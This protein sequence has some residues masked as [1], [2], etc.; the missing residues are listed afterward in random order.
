MTGRTL[1]HYKILDKLGQGGMGVLYRALD[2]HLDRTVAIKVL[3]PEAIG[4]PER[5]RRFVL[6]AKA[7]SA[8]NH[9][10]II[11]IYD[12]D[13]AGGVDFIA[14]EYVDGQSLDRLI[15][16]GP[17]PKEQALGYGVQIAAALAAAHA[18]GIVHRDIKPANVMV[19]TTGLVKVLDFG[20]AKLTER[21]V[22]DEAAPTVTA[23]RETV[24]GVVLGTVAYMSPE[25]AEGK[26][27]D[28]RSDVFSFGAM[29]YEMLAGRR[30]FAGDSN[31]SILTAILHRPPEPIDVSHDLR[32]IL[33][34][35]L[36]KRREA[37]Y[38]SAAEMGK[39]LEA[40][41]SR[42]M[43]RRGPLAVAAALSIAALV[44]VAIWLGVRA[45]RV[46]WARNVALPEIAGL[47][48]KDRLLAAEHLARQ[49]ERYLPADPL[50]QR[51]RGELLAP[52]SIRTEPPGADV[53]VRDY[54]DTDDPPRW[55]HLGRSPLE[56]VPL[57]RARLG[58]R[59]TREGFPALEGA[60]TPVGGFPVFQ[61]PLHSQSATPEGM[62]WIPAG[63]YVHPAVTPLTIEGFWL[64]RYEVTN[65]QYKQFVDRGGYRNR[66]YWKQPFIKDGRALPWEQAMAEF[67][68]STGRPGPATWELGTFPEGRA[69]FPV[70]GVSWH[71]AAA[72]AEFAGKSLPTVYHWYRAAEIFISSD[73]LRLSNLSGRGPAP[74]G[75]F[76]GLGPFGAYDM[77]GNI[78]E[79]CWNP[80][81]ERRYILGG[82]WTE[83]TYLYNIP[84]ARAP[85]ERSPTHGFRCARQSGAPSQA[86]AGAV[87]FVVRDRTRDKPAGDD[88]FR[89]YK[90]VHSYDR[91]ELKAAIESLDDTSEYWR[92]EKVSFQ[93]AYGNERVPAYLLLPKNA[94]PPYQTVVYFP[95]AGVLN[96]RSS[97]RLDLVWFDFIVRSGRAVMYPVYKGTYERGPSRYY[98]R[99]GQ[100]NLWREMNLQ[101]SK[102]LGRSI[103]YLETR[104]DI[105]RQRLAY[106]GVSLGAAQGPRLMAVEDRFRTGVLLEGGFFE[107]VAPEVDP[108]HFAPRVKIPTLMIN[109]RDDFLFPLE[110]SQRPLFRLLGT[111][112]KDK[113][114]VLFNAGHDIF[115]P[116][117]IKVVLDWLDRYLGPVKPL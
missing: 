111:P 50:I 114:H 13:Q 25:Q 108:L 19:T 11:T 104:P 66:D 85:F 54:L 103:D 83:G 43:F 22:V 20:L 97:E 7:A 113:R 38:A 18:A 16:E 91:T 86:L 101:W 5:K 80:A 99:F 105:D 6:E 116:E 2:T 33:L 89:V 45:S 37:R 57:P 81:G 115:N 71:E 44:A 32:R 77:A 60:I 110:G 61:F 49:V 107:K 35:S 30:P 79:W 51:L 21:V 68:D 84:D 56:R 48:E 82:A 10:N 3:R 87:T 88:V 34:R 117:V 53:Y 14:M 9:P 73:I 93:A 76:R 47:V 24:E 4:D 29:L 67:R 12:I 98:H 102:D 17:L 28:A 96:V 58:F 109:G 27:V 55:E 39:D 65:K 62:V 36:E 95:G 64:D 100:P 72:Y 23:G 1:A 78:K 59:I 94:P 63:T 92:K 69:D 106:Y 8:L 40:G 15:A 74:V 70:G 90:E 46:R 41:R 52:V 112:E 26:P 31:L 75:S 42:P